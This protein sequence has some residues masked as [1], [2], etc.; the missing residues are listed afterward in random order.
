LKDAPAEARIVPLLNK[1]ETEQQ[2]RQARRVARQILQAQPRVSHVVI[3]AVQSSRPVREV[4]R[5]VT[6]VVLAAGEANRMGQTKQLLP[7]GE[8][9][10]LGRTLEQLQSSLVHDILLVTGHEREAV[11]AA[12]NLAAVPHIHNPEYAAGEMISSLQCALRELAGIGQKAIGAVLVVLADQPLVGPDTYN[13]LLLAYWQ[14]RGGLVAPAYE[15]KRGNPVLIDRHYFPALFNLPGQT[16]PRALLAHYPSD[17]H[18]E[19][20]DSDAIFHDIDTPELYER[21]KPAPPLS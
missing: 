3:G 9:T 15:G 5:R 12:A 14:G 8:T 18:L 13:R 19:A 1:V 2:L 4:Q 16:P 6:A 7:W 10:I 20:V 17:L 21:W 11:G